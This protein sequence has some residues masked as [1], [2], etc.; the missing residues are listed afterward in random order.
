MRLDHYLYKNG[1]T[2]SRNKAKELILSQK[3]SV[4]NNIITKASFNINNNLDHKIEI[5]Q[6]HVYVSRAADKLKAFLSDYIIEIT[7]RRCLDIGS[8]TG[9]FVEVLLE[10]GAQKVVAVDVGTNQLHYSLR[11]DPRVICKEQ[12]DIRNYQEDTCF[13]VVTCDVSFVG[14]EYIIEDIDRLAC[15]DIIILFK[16]QF[17]V[18]KEVK[19]TKKGVVKNPRA[20]ALAQKKFEA[21]CLILGWHLRDK[22]ASKIYGKEGNIEFFYHYTKR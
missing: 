7:G 19:R 5:L 14:I 17:E 12:T 8:S 9:G 20:I 1:Y 15:Q 13:D 18:G 2:N 16:P 10:N 11:N 6:E 21:L 22:R 3:V 4:N